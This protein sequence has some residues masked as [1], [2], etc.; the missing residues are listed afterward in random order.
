M[1]LATLII[2]L[3]LAGTALAQ[4]PTGTVDLL[5]QANTYTP[6]WYRGH[7][8]PTAGSVVKVVALPHIKVGGGLPAQAGEASARDLIF[9]WQKDGRD[10]P[11][12]SGAGQDT[13]SYIV[14]SGGNTIAVAVLNRT[15][16][17]LAARRLTLLASEPKV[18]LYEEDPLAGTA[19]WQAVATTTLLAEP[20]LTVRAEPY[21]F[22][23]AAVE[24]GRL[25][26]E[27]KLNGKKIITD[28]ANTQLLT[29]A[30]PAEGGGENT[31]ELAVSNLANALQS[32]KTKLLLKFNQ[33]NFS[34]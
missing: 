18:V 26:Y 10:V 34:F 22:T 14:D 11:S 33:Q 2:A 9:R 23:R 8:L 25:N 20:E 7:S 13:L 5:W 4:T 12:V 31:I 27:W 3:T 28:A 30:A 32:A 16:T 1:K 17:L 19:Y 29:F 21:F 24:A 15:G 6:P